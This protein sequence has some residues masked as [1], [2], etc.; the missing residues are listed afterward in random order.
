M[1]CQS[2]YRH[3]NAAVVGPVTCSASSGDGGVSAGVVAS[4][5][6]DQVHQVACKVY[7]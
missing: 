7:L 3:N 4:H 5:G 2:L 6:V 1:E